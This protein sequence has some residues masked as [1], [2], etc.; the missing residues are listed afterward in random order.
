MRA[1]PESAA[2]RPILIV[3][4]GTGPTTTIQNKFKCVIEISF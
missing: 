1:A 4:V 3:I 2:E